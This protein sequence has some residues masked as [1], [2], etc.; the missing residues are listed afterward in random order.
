MPYA[1][2]AQAA[3]PGR[4]VVAFVGD[5]GFTMLMGE[6]ATA[7]KYKLP[8]KIFIAKNNS[9]G[10]IRWEQMMF[11]G[12][13]EYGVELQDIDFVKV[14]E[15]CGATGLRAER[16]DEV[17]AARRPGTADLPGPVVVEALVDPF[18]P[19]MPG[20]PQAGAGPALCRGAPRRGRPTPG[21]S[22]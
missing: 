18:E 6:I 14:A 17:D 11:L 20:S 16:P 4:Q 10:M 7:V 2:G 8:V 15:A 5:G 22:A 9:L 1:L 19:I 13:P 12:N 3:F 21:A